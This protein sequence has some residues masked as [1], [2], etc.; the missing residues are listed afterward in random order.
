MFSNQYEFFIDDFEKKLELISQNENDLKLIEDDLKDF[1][2]DL[3]ITLGQSIDFKEIEAN[4]N[5]SQEIDIETIC[6]AAELFN[7][8]TNHQTGVW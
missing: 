3:F 1:I 6:K 8:S 2:N 4:L 5:D 7:L